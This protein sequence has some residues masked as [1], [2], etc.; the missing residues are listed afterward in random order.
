MVVGRGRQIRVVSDQRLRAE[1]LA[2]PT[3]F[4]AYEMIR[5]AAQPVSVAEVTE[6]VGV[7]HNAVRVHL[8]KL[9]DAG[10]VTETREAPR[11]RGRP[12]LLY[13]VAD[14]VE[15]PPGADPYRA[16][17]A[18]LARAV[19]DGCSTHE[20][21]LAVGHDA[22]RRHDR[23]DVEDTVTVIEAEAADLGFDPERRG[24]D[25]QPELVLRHCP[26]A[27]VAAADPE[28]ICA[29]HL[30]IAEGIAAARGDVTVLGMVVHDPHQAG[31]R[32]R[33]ERQP[34]ATG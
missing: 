4:A 1:A 17:S 18:M 31:C 12:R 29:L 22:A 5:G 16:L 3:R 25:D 2:D 7:H 15:Q 34:G 30:G 26:F 11:G 8:A 20:V 23:D 33:M 27:D 28:H 9:R 19:R 32:L 24:T 14:P 10:L 6:G 13:A 21:G